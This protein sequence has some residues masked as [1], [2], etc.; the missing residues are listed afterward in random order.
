MVVVVVV[1]YVVEYDAE[2]D[3]V[4]DGEYDVVE[5]DV[6]VYDIVEYGAIVTES[7]GV[8][9]SY[10]VLSSSSYVWTSYTVSFNN[11]VVVGAVSTNEVF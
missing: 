3:T 10:G 11:D 9:I 6:V 5:Y 2:Y 8:V 4:Y 7:Y 1:V